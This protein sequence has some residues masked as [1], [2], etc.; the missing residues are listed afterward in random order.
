MKT[1][2]VMFGVPK[3]SQQLVQVAASYNIQTTYKHPLVKVKG[4]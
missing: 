1:N 3:Y 2:A 4:N